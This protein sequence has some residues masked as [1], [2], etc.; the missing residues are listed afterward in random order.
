VPAIAILAAVLLT[1]SS[2]LPQT[3]T[4]E[5][6]NRRSVVVTLE[7]G[8]QIRAAAR[9]LLI[10]KHLKL[11][12]PEPALI[13]SFSTMRMGEWTLGSSLDG[14]ELSL[15]YPIYTT[16]IVRRWQAIRIKKVAGRWKALGISEASAH[17][18]Y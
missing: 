12:L 6:T 2:P 3:V 4:I 11:P 1:G 13:D 7:D 15:T 16:E 18:T 17:R 9:Q 5:L 8:E 10:R 14:S